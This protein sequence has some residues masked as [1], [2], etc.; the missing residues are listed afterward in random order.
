MYTARVQELKEFCDFVG[1]ECKQILAS[2]KTK[3]LSPTCNNQ[4]YVHVSCIEVMFSF[5]RKMPDD[6][7]KNV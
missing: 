7:E 5:P 6:A 2:V 3:W 4:S 1:V